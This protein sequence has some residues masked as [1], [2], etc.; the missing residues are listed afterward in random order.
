M[1]Q[2]FEDAVA[3]FDADQ[4][5]NQQADETFKQELQTSKQVG[6]IEQ[7]RA[8]RGASNGSALEWT[9]W[10]LQLPVSWAKGLLLGFTETAKAFAEL[11]PEDSVF[12]PK[13]LG[14]AATSVSDELKTRFDDALP[15]QRGA[16]AAVADNFTE[17]AGRFA[18]GMVGPGRVVKAGLA[19][20]PKALQVIAQGAVAG[21]TAF[22]PKQ[23]NLDALIAHHTSLA[24][25][26]T[27]FLATDPN[28]SDVVNRA[29]NAVESVVVDVFGTAA[30]KLVMKGLETYRAGRAL[31]RAKAVSEA[32]VKEAED[33][34]VP[35]SEPMP[36]PEPVQEKPASTNNGRPSGVDTIAPE[37]P[38]DPAKPVADA[39]PATDMQNPRNVLPAG[40]R[41]DATPQ[42]LEAATGAARS[43]TGQVSAAIDA[44]G[45]GL[46]DFNLNTIDWKTFGS[47]AD[48]IYNVIETTSRVFEQNIDE[49]KGG[50]Q[51]HQTTAKLARLTGGTVEGVSKLFTDV[52]GEGGI[53]ARLLAADKLML[54]SAGRV[55]RL[56]KLVKD[57]TGADGVTSMAELQLAVEQ[58]AAIQA[59]VKG[60]RTEVARALN[61]MKIMRKSSAVDFGTLSR[62]NKK[63]VSK[64]ADNGSLVDFNQ[65]V[66]KAAGNRFTDMALELWINGLLSGPATHAANATSNLVKTVLSIPERG[67]AAAIGAVRRALGQD[68]ETVRAREV[69]AVTHGVW[70]GLADAFRLP[71]KAVGGDLVDHILKWDLAGAKQLLKDHEQEFGTAYRSIAEGGPVLDEA[72]KLDHNARGPALHWDPSQVQPGMARNAIHLANGIGSIIR[73]PGAALQTSDEVFKTI[74]Y[75]QQLNALALR[76]AMEKADLHGAFI[77]PGQRN[78]IIEGAYKDTLKNVPED[79]HM[80][81]IDFAQHQTFTNKL[82]PAGQAFLNLVNK[83]PVLRLVFPFVRTPVNILKDFTR[84]TPTPLVN[85][86]RSEFR[87]KLM[88]GGAE[89]DLML[90]RMALGTAAIAGVWRLAESGKLR[91]GGIQGADTGDL[92]GVKPYSAQAPDGQWYQFNRL[93][94][95]G[96]LIG[97]VADLHD[98]I[99]RK[100]QADGDNTHI[101]DLAQLIAI[102]AAKNAVSKTWLQGASGVVEALS[103]PERKAGP[104]SA[105]LAASFIP[106]YS[107]SRT[108]RSVEDPMAR[109]VFSFADHLRD[110]LPGLSEGLGVRRDWL[111]RAV[112]HGKPWLN[113]IGV[114]EQ[115]QDPVDKELARLQFPTSMPDRSIDGVPLS[116][117]Q[118]S[119]LLELRG[120][121]GSEGGKL[122]DKLAALISSDGYKRLSDSPDLTIHQGTKAAEIR[123]VVGAYHSVATEALLAEDKGLRETWTAEYKRR[124]GAK[125]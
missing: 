97:S 91:G 22:D 85:V 6:Q 21:Y 41:R 29:R 55:N 1:G 5:K 102:A 98:I 106:F 84:Y 18:A 23:E 114:S 11:G 31:A 107:A 12:G 71:V 82:G 65:T 28:D 15:A 89:T 95:M 52:R 99:E 35:E 36:P 124:L 38:A 54:A 42:Q 112:E 96:T 123:R 81:A 58:H 125:Q 103:D 117:Q 14:D 33:L 77:A 108:M 2:R 46:S 9:K 47:S 70:Q 109:D 73:S 53:S 100:Y 27:D 17:G 66:R 56:A 121:L 8:A 87:R 61:A 16:V 48:D 45:G 92:L 76:R 49:A 94:P 19:L 25:P 79:L 59:A 116:G 40:L 101:Q 20:A 7:D 115:S 104:W 64:L 122:R 13:G 67:T 74:A 90:S 93:E 34:K 105:Q 86:V 83:A 63:L 111:G 80:A 50:V 110:N 68:T 75:R 51:S 119:R 30:G 24:K 118:Y 60:S 69:L 43:P 113:P 10:G 4:A 44:N 37:A 3:A 88:Q 72:A 32:G 120:T 78:G 39:I 57:A 62:V 26:I